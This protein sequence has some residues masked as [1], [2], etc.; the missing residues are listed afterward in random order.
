MEPLTYYSNIS[1]IQKNI[2][3]YIANLN[4]SGSFKYLYVY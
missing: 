3:H 4:N 1:A 2:T